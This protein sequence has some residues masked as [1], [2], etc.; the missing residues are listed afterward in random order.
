MRVTNKMLSDTVLNGLLNNTEHLQQQLVSMA[1]QKRINSPSDDPAGMSRVLGYRTDLSSIEQYERNINQG[2]SWL[3]HTESVLTE[4]YD[5]LVTA[6]EVAISQA[7]ATAN[8]DT[9]LAMA[10]EIENIYEHMLSLSNTRL[11]GRYIFSG[12]RTSQPAFNPDGTYNGDT[13]VISVATGQNTTVKVSLTGQD[14]FLTTDVFTVLDNLKLALENDDVAG[15]TGQLAGLQS[16][17]DHVNLK[18]AEIGSRANQMET[19]E[20]ILSNLKL[21]IREMLS[22]TEDLDFI[23][24]AMDLTA[25]QNAY[26]A[27]LLASKEIMRMN[28]ANF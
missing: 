28:L 13:N 8:Q 2:A 11:G 9:R 6:Q 4:A 23:Q 21:N 22:K 15:I 17:M 24:A 26:Q 1:S 20:N 14:V 19:T 5:L 12:Y 25:Q 16:S 3:T 7:N 10:K 27:S 18:I